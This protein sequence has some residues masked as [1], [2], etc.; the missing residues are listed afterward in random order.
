M[1][2]VEITEADAKAGLTEYEWRALVEAERAGGASV[3]ISTMIART[4][5]RVRG[6]VIT[7]DRNTLGPDG[8]VPGELLDSTQVL[9]LEALATSIPAAG[10][11]LDA[12]R[13]QRI[14]DAKRELERV[15]DGKLKVSRPGSSQNVPSD[16]PAV[17]DGDYGG[18]DPID[19]SGTR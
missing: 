6:Y 4:V 1:D 7:N 9:L 19:F 14:K 17:D 2:W 10:L 18:D 16:A 3:Q 11:V 13:M 8:Y 5:N 12:G 15:A